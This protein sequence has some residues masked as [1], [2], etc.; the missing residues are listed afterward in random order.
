VA[1]QCRGYDNTRC[2]RRDAKPFV[3]AGG[4]HA[5]SQR[6]E[7]GVSSAT[8]TRDRTRHTPLWIGEGVEFAENRCERCGGDEPP[9]DWPVA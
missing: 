2:Q 6:D 7:E 8:V 3:E 1:R 4:E 9:G 5:G